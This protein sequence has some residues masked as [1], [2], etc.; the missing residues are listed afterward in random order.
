MQ[1]TQTNATPATPSVAAEPCL[2]AEHAQV[3]E[4]RVT[5]ADLALQCGLAGFC[6][7]GAVSVA[8]AVAP[9]SIAVGL[10]TTLGGL[11]LWIARRAAPPAWMTYTSIVADFALFYLILLT[12]H[13]RPGA[14]PALTLE[15]PTFAFLFVIVALRAL[16]FN[17]AEMVFTGVVAALG[18]AMV[19][20]F[21]LA[22]A[23]PALEGVNVAKTII[24]QVE[25]IVAIGCL[26]GLICLA[27]QRGALYLR[28]ASADAARARAALAREVEL[29]RQLASEAKARETLNKRLFQSAY[30]DR[31]TGLENRFA[32]LRRAENAA[33][34]FANM[35]ERG[36][37]VALI[38]LNR[39][40]SF[41]DGFGR[42]AGDALLKQ[43]AL[44]LQS[45]LRPGEY[46]GRVGADEFAVVFA[47]PD[48]PSVAVALGQRFRA[49]LE[50]PIEAE[51]HTFIS[52]ATVGLALAETGDGGAA[53][54]SFADI[55]L[56]EA[57]RHGGRGVLLHEP[58]ARAQ[59]SQRVGLEHALRE[60][61]E[62]NELALRYQPIVRLRDGAVCGWEALA[63]WSRGGGDM[64]SPATFI[65]IA[66]ETG[67]IV[68]I[69]AWAL[70][71]ASADAER[72]VAAGAD[73]A[74]F[75]TVNVSPR[76]FVNPQRLVRSVRDAVRRFPQ[77]K[78]E[79]TESAVVENPARALSVMQALR[80]LGAE[81]AL[82][83][84]GTGAS[85]LSQLR[86]FP[87]KTLKI[88]Q[89]FVRDDSPGGRRYLRS[90]VGIAAALQLDTV[91]EGIETEADL[92]ACAEC[93]VTYG[94][95]YLL[96][97]PAAAESVIEACRATR[98][99]APQR[100][101]QA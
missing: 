26:C 88:D 6:T 91:A 30:Y 4:R 63:R 65:P 35:P 64:V 69:G 18:W 96:G 7:T 59:I 46:L 47:C 99:R 67:T 42:A 53:V 51:G 100:L 38:D 58:T 66:E 93:G 9:V 86:R 16:R 49:A 90:I 8:A 5:W 14:D 50:A 78:L 31:L 72:F 94:Q 70:A 101:L 3:S 54:F 29:N 13:W 21:A 55:A 19:T 74:A 84:F 11:R 37:G 39:F 17:M 44:R 25:R 82:D 57:K 80:R 71:S 48:L 10:L 95:G 92:A 28:R 22:T 73:P 68:D 2:E 23:G 56:N 77:L 41:N 34:V 61:V 40:R 15:A 75:V 12:F 60:A 89:S 43:A 45:V 76:Q 85:S 62:R 97:K 87:F 24:I 33:S 98:V 52:G 83:D 79:L 27:S 20:A 1:R 81:L 36:F 32:I